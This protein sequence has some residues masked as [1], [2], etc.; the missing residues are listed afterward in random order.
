M[1]QQNKKIIKK[2][3]LVMKEGLFNIIKKY[4]RIILYIIFLIIIKLLKQLSN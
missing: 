3:S 4:N 2:F 1:I